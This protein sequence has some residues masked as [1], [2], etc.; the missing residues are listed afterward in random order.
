MCFI[1]A[2]F[3]PLRSKRATISP[4]RPRSNASGFTR[5]R[6][7]SKSSSWVVAEAETVL[8]ALRVTA[9]RQHFVR[10]PDPGAAEQGHAHALGRKGLGRKRARG[11]DEPHRRGVAAAD[12]LQVHVRL[13]RELVREL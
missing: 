10:L 9:S 5:I 3:R 4:V 1:A 13:P 12:V 2:I 6:V 8:A 7:R 11:A